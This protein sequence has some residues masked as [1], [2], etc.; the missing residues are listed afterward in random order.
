M[1]LC[2]AEAQ[3]RG[4]RRQ[5]PRRGRQDAADGGYSAPEEV[6][7]YGASDAVATY[8]AAGDDPLAALGNSIPG[9]PGE[10][11]PIYAE[12][13]ESGFTCDGQVDGGYYADPEQECQ[14]YHV[15]LRDPL[16]QE[17]LY[18]V[19]FLCPNGTIFNQEIFVC[20]WWFNVDCGA[21]ASLYGAVEGAFG[22]DGGAGGDGDVGECP[23]PSSGDD[24][25]GA[26]SN[27]W[28]PGQR[29][30]DCPSNGLCCFD[31]CADTC[32]D[33]PK[34][35]PKPYEPPVE[36]VISEAE[37]ENKPD[38]QPAPTPKPTTVTEGYE[39][40]VPEVP[41][42]FPKPKPPPPELPTLYGPPSL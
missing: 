8:E 35:T 28:S 14:A 39:Y 12:V 36:P 17:S 9:V 13:P 20:D 21:A 3:R 22:S 41:L 1:C 32:V 23:A 26:V 40:P 4:G 38:F 5:A 25:A 7:V 33:G 24:C 30:T 16:D 34:P 18:P 11:Y 37:T 6:P 31:G 10:D 27:C 19:S 42:E 15:C 2:M 29:D